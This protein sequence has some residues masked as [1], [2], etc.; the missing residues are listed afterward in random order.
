MPLLNRWLFSTNA[1]DIGTLYLIFALFSGLFGALLSLVIRLELMGP[2]IQILQGN[3]QF[4]NVIVTA[5]AFIMVFYF[6]MPALIGGFGNYFVP[7]MIGAIDMS[8]PRLN[9]IS[10]WLLP[11]SLLLLLSS[12]F[13]ENGAGT[14]WT[15]GKKQSRQLASWQPEKKL[16][17]MLGTPQIGENYSLIERSSAVRMFSTRGQLAWENIN[18]HQRLNV[19][20]SKDLGFQQW[21]MCI[22]P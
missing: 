8:F 15:V 13:V 11:P 22:C 21:G 16:Y 2:G 20:I 5:H 4:F 9:N 7:V 17:S 14:G 6:I 18:S 1:K 3:H 19:E 10:F 12:A